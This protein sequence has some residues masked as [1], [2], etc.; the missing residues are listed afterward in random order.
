MRIGNAPTGIVVALTKEGQIKERGG[1]AFGGGLGRAV[2]YAQYPL[3]K[4]KN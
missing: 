2:E 1:R 4:Y 3:D